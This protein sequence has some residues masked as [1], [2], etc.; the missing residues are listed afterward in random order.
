MLWIWT[1]CVSKGTKSVPRR[2]V[3]KTWVAF[4]DAESNYYP[5]LSPF[6]LLCPG[7]MLRGAASLCIRYCAWA[8][9]PFACI[10]NCVSMDHANVIGE[11]LILRGW[12]AEEF[13]KIQILSV[14]FSPLS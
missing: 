7:D 3:D 5:L 1:S 8:A 10:K 6:D 11:Q 2:F 4:L 9:H 14:A 12:G 13:L